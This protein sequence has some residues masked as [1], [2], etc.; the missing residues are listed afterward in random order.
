MDIAVAGWHRGIEGAVDNPAGSILAVE[1]AGLGRVAN[2]GIERP[3]SGVGNGD[4]ESHGLEQDVTRG[5][6]QTDPGRQL[7]RLAAGVEAGAPRFDLPHPLERALDA[8]RRFSRRNAL[9]IVVQRVD[10]HEGAHR[11]DGADH[12]ALARA[13]ITAS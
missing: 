3:A 5:D 6:G 4:G 7:H 9:R 13:S 12:F 8:R 10:G 11:R 2:C 1:A